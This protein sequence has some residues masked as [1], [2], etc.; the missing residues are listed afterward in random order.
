MAKR[1]NS[2]GRTKSK[3]FA[4]GT[5]ALAVP[6][7][8]NKKIGNAA[9][10]Y[11]AQTSCPTSCP[12]FAGGGCYAENGSIGKFV[13]APLNRAANAVEHDAVDVAKAEAAAIDKMKVVPGEDLRLHTVG[14][15]ATDEAAQVVAAACARYRARGGGPIWTYT[16]AWRDVARESWGEVSVLASCE[17][18][19]DVALAKARG[20]ATQIT[21]EGFVSDRRHALKA[22]EGE[23]AAGVDVLPCPEQTRGVTCTDCR[24]CFDDAKLRDRGYSIAFETHGTP[25]TIRQATKAL[26]TPDDPDRKLTTRQL[27]PRVI[28]EIEAEGE[29]VTNAELARR[30]QCS[31]SSVAQM[32]KT[33]AR[34]GD[35]REEAKQSA[36]RS[37]RRGGSKDQ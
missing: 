34:E 35:E 26:R 17:T 14:D 23:K 3:Q 13:T 19:A 8:A 24:L 27:I 30:L 10:T 6:T 29:P 7:S 15:C 25:F 36:C 31:P 20:Y 21:V 2:D 22:V 5:L 28:A 37:A 9:T 16:H 33:L 32:R 11:A 1:T 18:A 4:R 12:F